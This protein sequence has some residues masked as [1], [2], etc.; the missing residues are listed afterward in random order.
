MFGLDK[1]HSLANHL[2]AIIKT[3]SLLIEIQAFKQNHSSEKII[4]KLM[5]RLEPNKQVVTQRMM[6][7]EILIHKYEEL[8]YKRFN[9]DLY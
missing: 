4:Q 3:K 7:V 1:G 2:A 9:K 8:L 6:E 5:D